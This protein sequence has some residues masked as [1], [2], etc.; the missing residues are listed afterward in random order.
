MQ[1]VDHI[2]ILLIFVALPIYST[3]I[4]KSLPLSDDI[5]EALDLQRQAFADEQGQEPGPDDLLF[6]LRQGIG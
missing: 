1:L 4:F 2:F 5:K 3:N 6:P